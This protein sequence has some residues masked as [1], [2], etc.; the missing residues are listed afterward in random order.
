MTLFVLYGDPRESID[1]KTLEDVTPHR[2]G[3]SSA[4]ALGVK[5]QHGVEQVVG[6]D[7]RGWCSRQLTRARLSTGRCALVMMNERIRHRV[8]KNSVYRQQRA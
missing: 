5:A 2:T 1:E 6:Y 7:E 3:C 4:W 8:D